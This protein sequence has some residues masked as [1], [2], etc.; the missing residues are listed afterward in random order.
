MKIKE[1]YIKTSLSNWFSE[2]KTY[3]DMIGH[4]LLFKNDV[5]FIQCE[6]LDTAV[7]K[8]SLSQLFLLGEDVYGN[9]SAGWYSIPDA[10]IH[11]ILENPQEE[12]DTNNTYDALR[13]LVLEKET[14]DKL[15]PNPPSTPCPYNY[16]YPHTYPPTPIYHHPEFTPGNPNHE[17]WRTVC[18]QHS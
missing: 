11:Y 4:Y 17:Q 5:G 8:A 3:T 12:D 15:F 6:V 14:M 7:N 16:P 13:R 1:K 18:G 9:V 2:N 10:D